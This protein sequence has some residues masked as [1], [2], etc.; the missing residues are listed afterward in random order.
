MHHSSGA[1]ISVHFFQAKGLAKALEMNRLLT[2]IL[3]QNEY[4]F[5]YRPLPL[6]QFIQIPF[7]PQQFVFSFFF[8]GFYRF[9]VGLFCLRNFLLT[10]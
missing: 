3:W 5:F 1:K 8:S 4:L 6:H 2:L 7:S 9:P 10:H